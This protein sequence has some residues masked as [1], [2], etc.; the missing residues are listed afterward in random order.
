MTILEKPALRTLQSSPPLGTIEHISYFAEQSKSFRGRKLSKLFEFLYQHNVAESL[1]YFIAQ[2]ET[3]KRNSP[4]LHRSLDTRDLHDYQTGPIIDAEF[5]YDP[6]QDDRYVFLAGRRWPK[7]KR[8]Y[9]L[10]MFL[11][12][13]LEMDGARPPEAHVTGGL[14]PVQTFRTFARP[15]YNEDRPAVFLNIL[16]VAASGL[17]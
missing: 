2:N 3:P 13:D 16:R 10:K 17:E 1:A 8:S 9:S 15:E 14:Y 12:N 7:S 5:H 6:F 11:S 4:E